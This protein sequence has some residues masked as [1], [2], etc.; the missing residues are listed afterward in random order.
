MN[1]ISEWWQMDRNELF[2]EIAEQEASGRD[3]LGYMKFIH[4]EVAKRKAEME[5]EEF[6]KQYEEYKEADK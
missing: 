2:K 6:V 1:A 5:W 3:I 4:F